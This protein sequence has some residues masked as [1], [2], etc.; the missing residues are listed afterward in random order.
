MWKVG[1]SSAALL[2]GALTSG[3]SASCVA[4]THDGGAAIA[5]AAPLGMEDFHT[6]AVGPF[7]TLSSCATQTSPNDV[8]NHVPEDDD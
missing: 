6:R 8:Q 4:A 5:M 3:P 1:R 7:R 2:G